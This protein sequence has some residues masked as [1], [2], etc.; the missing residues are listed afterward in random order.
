MFTYDFIRKSSKNVLE[1]QLHI[2]CLHS[3]VGVVFCC[4]QNSVVYRPK[5]VN[6]KAVEEWESI[7]SPA[8]CLDA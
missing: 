7:R 5:C 6:P 3:L 4:N 2:Q 8:Y 1:T